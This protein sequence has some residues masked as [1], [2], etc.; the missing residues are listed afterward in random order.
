M[1]A[2]NLQLAQSQ[3]CLG[4]EQLWHGEGLH[5]TAAVK[6]RCLEP[7]WMKSQQS[8]GGSQ[9]LQAPLQRC[10]LNSQKEVDDPQWAPAASTALLWARRWPGPR[11]LG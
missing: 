11:A 10:L 1:E 3:L 6:Q 9:L 7:S 2:D 8:Q 5:T 4:T